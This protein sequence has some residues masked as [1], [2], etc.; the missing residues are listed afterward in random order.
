MAEQTFRSPGFFDQ[1]VD[2]TQREN[3]PLGTPAGVIGTAEKGPAFVPVTVGSFSDFQAKFGGLNSKRFGPYAVREFLKNRDAVTYVRVL[4]AGANL[5]VLDIN[6]TRAQGSVKNSGFKL[7][8]TAVAANIQPLGHMGTVQ[9]LVAKHVVSASEAFGFP[10]FTDNT[11]VGNTDANLVRAMLFTTNDARLGVLNHNAQGATI[12]T[13]FTEFARVGGTG[14][15]LVDEF[16]LFVSS[17][18]GTSYGN[19]DLIAGARIFTASLNPRSTNYIRNVLNT[20]PDQFVS[21]KHLLYACFDV[22]PELATVSRQANSVAMLSGSGASSS[23]NPA[24]QAFRVAYGRFDT[25]YTTPK[26]TQFISQP[27]GDTEFDLFHFETIFDGAYANGNFKV[28]IK[29]IRGSSDPA[30]ERG[31]FTVQIRNYEDNDFAPQILE[32]FPGCNLDPSS[33]TYVARMIGDMKAFFNFDAED[34]DERRVSV[35]GQFPNKS[36]YVRIVMHANVADRIIPDKALPF[37]FRGLPALKTN[38]TNSDALV[39]GGE[40]RLAGYSAVDALTGSVVPPVPLTFKATR[41][42]VST[43]A[44]L[45][46][47]AGSTE[48]VDSRI[49]FGAKTTALASTGTVGNANLNANVGTAVNQGLLDQLK[50]LNIEKMNNLQT[51]SGADSFNDNKFTLARVGLP[52][53][54]GGSST[55]V[56]DDTELTGTVKAHMLDAAYLRNALPDSTQYTLTVASDLPNRISFGTLL[57]Q[58]SSVTFNRFTDFMKFTNVFYGGFDGVN[59][60]DKNA[61]RMNDKSVSLDSAGG[62]ASGYVPSGFAANQNGVGKDNSGIRSYQAAADIMTDPFAVNTN[63]LAIPGIRESFVTDHAMNRNRDYGMSIYLLDIPQ[64]DDSNNRIYDDSS[65]RP[66]VAKT[67]VQF[68]T[69]RVDNNSAGAYFPDVVIE[70]DLNNER[71]KVPPSVAAIAAL[72]FND[73]VS[74]PWFAPAGFNRGS[75]DFVKNTGVRLTAGD[76]DT[77]YDAR[78]NPIANFPQQGFVIFGQKTLQAAQSAL[79]RVNVRRLMLEVKRAVSEIANRILFEQNTPATRARFISQ[80]TPVLATIQAQSGI[81]NF[82]V[83]MD[84]SNNSTDDVLSNRLNGKVILVPTRAI[85]FISLDFVITNS[86][87]SFE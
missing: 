15:V 25:R 69:R 40:G 70:D 26:T 47:A 35:Q 55:G 58:T 76:R 63:I 38:D 53:Q 33:E 85:E 79:D 77:L 74:F 11:T 42:A 65:E 37:G 39:V 64:F 17:T 30:Q 51:G 18:A 52:N 75:L 49:Y 21:Q 1:E 29:A 41:G 50:F 68:E 83:V 8:S 54:A 56:Y 12:K 44:G 24:S 2:L 43:T 78:V 87:V 23:D 80:V 48:V 22:E 82:K 67:A 13:A 86:G 34:P 60:M 71:V 57:A 31:T 36:Q 46:G 9:F 16:K 45:V 81:E 27:F 32:E 14:A 66:S 84:D 5:S 4:G 6:N 59:L 72:G 3:P 20:D 10:I 61:R 62:A 28:S 19:D 7:A 73:A